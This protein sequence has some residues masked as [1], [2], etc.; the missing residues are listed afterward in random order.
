MEDTSLDSNPPERPEQESTQKSA[1]SH[2]LVECPNCGRMIGK[3]VTKCS[4]CDHVVRGTSPQLTTKPVADKPSRPLTET[5]QSHL[6]YRLA[7]GM[8]FIGALINVVSVLILVGA[9]A[10]PDIS[11]IVSA[12]IDVGLAIG[13]LQMRS[14]ARAWVLVR[15]VLGA[16]LVPIVRFLTLDA[17][18][19]ILSLL[20]Q[21]G[22][23][24][25]LFIVLTGQ[26]KTWRIALASAVFVVFA[27]CLAV[28]MMALAVIGVTLDSTPMPV[29]N[30]VGIPPSQN[31]IVS[32]PSD[33]EMEELPTLSKLPA[34]SCKETERE[35]ICVVAPEQAIRWGWG[36]CEND[37]EM[38]EAKKSE[39][40]IVLL[41]DGATVP[42]TLIYQRDRVHNRTETPYC[43]TWTIKLSD[44]HSGTTVTLENRASLSFFKATSNVFV[45]QVK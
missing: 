19:G 2:Y 14:G 13:L 20:M 31:V 17:F 16:I 45:I 41:V 32:K 26:S 39:L 33:Q 15:T 30:S 5:G 8:L 12:I 21:W 11:L 4:Y 23:C 1:M 40:E 25:A 18:E 9:D 22:Y 27:L 34:G 29:M 36:F 37:A 43:H 10:F 38:L 24:G 6:A 3:N 35:R 44:W 42:E 7:A 28:P